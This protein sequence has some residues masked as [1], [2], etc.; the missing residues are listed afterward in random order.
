MKATRKTPAER[1]WSRVVD[2]PNGCREFTGCLTHS[3]YGQIYFNGR[4]MGAHRMAWELVNGPILNGL[5]LLHSCDN[6]PCCNVDHLSLGTAGENADDR[7]AKGRTNN[8][9]TSR[10]HCLNGHSYDDPSVY[11]NSLGHRT[12]RKCHSEYYKAMGSTACPICNKVITTHNLAKHVR[13]MHADKA[14]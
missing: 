1:L 5:H 11:I 12:C 10:T 14:A 2:Q 7:D 3:G 8:G 13:R 6:P 4:L 9:Q